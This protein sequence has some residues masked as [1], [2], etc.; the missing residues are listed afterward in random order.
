MRPLETRYPKLQKADLGKANTIVLL[1]G[2][3][4]S[5]VLRASEVLRISKIKSQ[6]SKII[7]SGTDPLNPQ[8]KETEEMKE[9]LVEQGITAK[10]IVLEGESRNT[11]ENAK[12]VRELVGGEPFFLVTSA[13]H[14]PRAQET[15]QKLGMNPVLAPTDF[16]AE[17]QYDILDFFPDAK[18]LRNSDLALHEYFGILWYTL[19]Y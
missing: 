16:K 6:K 12:N 3:E 9:F 13:Y 7:I 2:G 17:G 11:F 5:D 4:E 10:N 15:F 19:K 8:K 1:L 14:M 18:N